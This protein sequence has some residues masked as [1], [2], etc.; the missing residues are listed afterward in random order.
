MGKKKE[1]RDTGWSLLMSEVPAVGFFFPE[2]SFHA[3]KKLEGDYI[4]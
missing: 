1:K 2:I 3:R 4:L